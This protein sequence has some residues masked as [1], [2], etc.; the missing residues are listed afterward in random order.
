MAPPGRPQRTRV[1]FDILAGAGI[2]VTQNGTNYTVINTGDA[3]GS[4][5][6]TT[7]SQANGDVSGPLSNL[8]IKPNVVTSAEIADNAVDAGLWPMLRSPALN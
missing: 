4:D 3:D 8:Q 6:L 2:D 1:V 5:D 7:A